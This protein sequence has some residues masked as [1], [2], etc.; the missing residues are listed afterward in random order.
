[1]KRL[2]FPALLTICII[3]GLLPIPV[4]AA[5]NESTYSVYSSSK[6]AALD[7]LT[8]RLA[9]GC[10]IASYETKNMYIKNAAFSYDNALAALA[11]TAEGQK[12]KAAEILDAFVTGIKND[13]YQSD[14]V[15]N[16]Y[17]TGDPT[18]LPGWW[19]GKWNE[20]AYQV[21]TNV[22]NSSFVALALLQYHHRWENEE[23]LQTAVTI[24]DW[25]LNNCQDNSAG[26]SAGYDGWPENGVVTTY[27]YKSTEHNIDAYAVFT[28]LYSLTGEEKYR[29]AIESALEFIHSMYDGSGYFYIGTTSDGV[30]PS[31]TNI[32]LDNQVWSALALGDNFSPYRNALE[33]ALSMKTS[34]GGFPFHKANSNGGFWCEGTAFTAL[35]FRKLGIDAE[36]VSALDALTNVQL[37]SGGFPAATVA[38]L[39]TGESWTYSNDPHIAPTAWYIMAVNGFNPYE[40]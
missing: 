34:E 1:M 30:T 16:A 37:D 23:Y 9:E 32:V 26:F 40:F 39:T 20:D 33:T 19:V 35:A 4:F 3:S 17:M 29:S 7:Y 31:K 13:R 11:F 21:G 27:F 22:G 12:E 28:Q 5:E 2:F 6:N 25:V 10:P 15:R 18:S 14:R 36:A 8:T 24:M 38:S